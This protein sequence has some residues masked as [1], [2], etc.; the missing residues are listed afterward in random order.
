M[1]TLTELYKLDFFFRFSSK[2]RQNSHNRQ[3][4]SLIHFVFAFIMITAIVSES[5]FKLLDLGQKKLFLKS[6]MQSI[7]KLNE[8]KVFAQNL[9]KYKFHIAEIAYKK[10]LKDNTHLQKC[11]LI[12]LS[13]ENYLETKEYLGFESYIQGNTADQFCKG[14]RERC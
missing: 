5:R 12:V 14:K 7:I 6:H 11:Y 3:S 8:K 4:S 10:S 1:K 13:F 9:N 2:K